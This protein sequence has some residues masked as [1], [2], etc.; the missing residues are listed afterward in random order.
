MSIVEMLVTADADLERRGYMNKTPFLEACSRGNL[1]L[2]KLLVRLGADTTAVVDDGGIRR[3]GLRPH[4]SRPEGDD[5]IHRWAQAS[6]INARL[7]IAKLFGDVVRI[8]IGRRR[9][10]SASRV[11]T[12]TQLVAPETRM[13]SATSNV[14]AGGRYELYS[15]YPLQIQAVAASIALSLGSRKR[16]GGLFETSMLLK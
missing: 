8:S 15:N 12:G 2:V 1:D 7:R 13:K 9:C 3:R 16:C 5:G 11:D 4:I 6:V 14:V 10:E